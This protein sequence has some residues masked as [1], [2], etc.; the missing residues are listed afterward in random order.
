MF[1]QIRAVLQRSQDT[2]WQDA[3]GAVSLMVI[4]IGGLHIPGYS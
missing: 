2:I 1:S 4:L 3:V